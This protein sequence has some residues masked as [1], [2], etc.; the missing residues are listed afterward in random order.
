MKRSGALTPGVSYFMVV[1]T[2]KDNAG[3]A[4]F[5]VGKGEGKETRPF[6][7]KVSYFLNDVAESGGVLDQ[8]TVAA[9]RLALADGCR[10]VDAQYRHAMARINADEAELKA[11][12]EH[13]AQFQQA[14]N[15]LASFT[16]KVVSHRGKGK[17]SSCAPSTSAKTVYS[18]ELPVV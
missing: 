12:V 13:E 14:L 3:S 11:K 9:R 15:H 17:D 4:S 5:S 7:V 6:L 18:E 10:E 8:D 2:T 1:A 16:A